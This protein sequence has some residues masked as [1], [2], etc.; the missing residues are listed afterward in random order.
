M[1][2][3]WCQ[4][5]CVFSL[6]SPANWYQLSCHSSP[7]PLWC[8]VTVIETQHEPIA[9]SSSVFSSQD[10]CNL[11]WLQLRWALRQS[12]LLELIWVHRLGIRICTYVQA[13]VHTCHT[14][15]TGKHMKAKSPEKTSTLSVRSALLWAIHLSLLSFFGQRHPGMFAGTFTCL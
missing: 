15:S 3:H 13:C 6:S 12:N 11:K 14:W 7:S 9:N 2:V 4:D 10:I 8:S 1:P 5:R